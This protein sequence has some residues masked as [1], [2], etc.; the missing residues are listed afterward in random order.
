MV[1]PDEL[2]PDFFDE[3]SRILQTL[4]RPENRHVVARLIGALA[5]PTHCPPFWHLQTALGRVFTDIDFASYRRFFPDL[6]RLFG[7][8]GYE[9]D[10]MVSRLFGEGRMLFHDP[11][12]SRHVDV[13][14]DRLHFSHTIP[15]DGRLEAD[16]QNLLLAP[17]Q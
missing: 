5:F 1:S 10:K 17:L 12:Y 9:E 8:L 7:A 14:F 2:R 3:R 16:S 13:F 6:Q 15:L 4:E 11:A